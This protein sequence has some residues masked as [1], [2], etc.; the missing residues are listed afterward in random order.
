MFAA[1][2]VAMAF[3]LLFVHLMTFPFVTKLNPLNYL[4]HITPAMA[5]AFASSSSAA[6]LPVTMSCVESTGRVPTTVS[7]FVLPL[8]ATI[9]MDGTAIYIPAACVWLAFLN[10]H[11]VNG[12]QYIILILLGTIGSAGAAPVPSASLVLILSAYETVF[13]GDGG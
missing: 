12:A 2:L 5:M 4:S 7:N 9:N 11:E 3:Q 13:G 10:G 6:T 1:T 8:G